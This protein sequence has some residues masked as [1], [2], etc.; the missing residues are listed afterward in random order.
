MSIKTYGAAAL[1]IG[2]SA[3]AYAQPALIMALRR[4]MRPDPLQMPPHA[5]LQAIRAV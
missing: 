3:S 4:L 5:Q 2:L 1:L